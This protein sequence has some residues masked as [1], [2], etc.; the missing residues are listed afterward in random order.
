M[1]LARSPGVASVDYVVRRP[2]A[3]PLADWVLCPAD[4]GPRPRDLTED[5]VLPRN[6]PGFVRRVVTLEVP[7]VVRASQPFHLDSL[8]RAHDEHLAVQRLGPA[9]VEHD[10]IRHRESPAPSNHPRA[11]GLAVNEPREV[12]SMTSWPAWLKAVSTLCLPSVWPAPAG[13]GNIEM[14]PLV[15]SEMARVLATL[16]QSRYGGC[17]PTSQS[18]AV[19]AGHLRRLPCL[20]VRQSSLQQ[21]HDHQESTAGEE[22]L[23]VGCLLLPILRTLTEIT[24]PPSW[25]MTSQAWAGASRNLA[26][27]YRSE[28]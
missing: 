23:Q 4:S 26:K 14:A 2:L 6:G 17:F 25:R 11:R 24:L 10:Q 1:K 3:A 22:S 28:P 7:T 16:T 5:S 13:S 21:V 15:R 27:L 18:T 20:Y 12:I 9:R 8:A 19:T